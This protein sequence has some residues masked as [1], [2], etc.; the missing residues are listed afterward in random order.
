M[1]VVIRSSILVT[2]LILFC[3]LLISSL[4]TFFTLEAE[5]KTEKGHLESN[6]NL[7]DSNYVGQMSLSSTLFCNN[8]DQKFR[9]GLRGDHWVLYNY[10]KARKEFQC[11]ESITY[12]THGGYEFLTNLEP[13]LQRWQG[14]LSIAVYAPGTDFQKALD[15]ILYY[16]ECAESDLV[17]DFVTF[18]VFFDFEHIPEQIPHWQSLLY[19]RQNCDASEEGNGELA[20]RSNVTTNPQT[21]TQSYKKQNGLDY[22]VNL[23]RNVARQTVSTH[24]VFPS[25]VELYPR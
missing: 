24:F 2:T 14:P 12:T 10:I 19:K 7:V 8:I 16:R 3:L 1:L 20:S 4:A 18:H 25:D 6:E 21:Q 13:L 17:Q 11:N 9:Q 5:S 22:P 15:S 23:A